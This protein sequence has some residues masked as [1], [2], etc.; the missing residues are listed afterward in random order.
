VNR[1]NQPKKRRRQKPIPIGVALSRLHDGAERLRLDVNLGLAVWALME[2]ANQEVQEKYKRKVSGAIEA[3]ELVANSLVL[4]LVLIV[5]RLFDKS[6]GPI[7][8]Q[9]KASLPVIAHLL[10]QKR[11]QRR[12]VLNAAD[13]DKSGAVV[14]AN[15][16]AF[17][18]DFAKLRSSARFQAS[19]RRVRAFRDHQV[20]HNILLEGQRMVE[21]PIYD[22]VFALL[23]AAC[24]LSAKASIVSGGRN[25]S[26][27]DHEQEYL[28]QA[29]RFWP[30]ALAGAFSDLRPSCGVQ[31]GCSS[32][33]MV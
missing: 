11:I 32:E 21:L 17:L 30:A 7:Q 2:T 10:G 19:L 15:A 18:K 28:R 6:R 3:Y 31:G 24:D 20:A 9:N 27:R 23:G 33:L 29:A 25:A 22:D 8:R 4:R 16:S 12:A 14:I 13:W 26:F 1:P 5:S